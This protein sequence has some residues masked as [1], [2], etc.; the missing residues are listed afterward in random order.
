ED[1]QV[2]LFHEKFSIHRYQ[3]NIFI[4]NRQL[5]NVCDSIEQE[6]IW[7]GE[8]Y[9]D[10]PQFNGRLHFEVCDSGI[11]AQWLRQTRLTLHFRK[12]GERLRLSS[13]RPSRSLKSHYQALNI[14][15][16]IR[17]ISPLI[18]H[19]GDLV[20]AAGIGIQCTYFAPEGH[21]SIN[22]KWVANT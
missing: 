4:S 19:A 22:L 6:F 15:F 13:N 5:E 3:K 17:K 12:G 7:A 11:C 10:F 18:S 14:P 2:T 1:A 21:S 9:L 8:A 16:W 20:F